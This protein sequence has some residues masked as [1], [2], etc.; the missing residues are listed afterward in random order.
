MR[1]LLVWV[2][3]A[4]V[5]AGA[6]EVQEPEGL[7]GRIQARMKE[8]LERL[9]DYVC[10]QTVER[11]TRAKPGKPLEKADTLRLEVGLIGD[12]E[13]FSWKDAGRF[14]EKDLS[15]MVGKGTVG[16]GNFALHAKHVFLARAA[17]FTY[18]GLV[19][20][21]SRKA[22]QYE[23]LVPTQ[24]SA[25]RVRV[26]PNEARV[27]FQGSFWVDAASLDLLKLGVVADEIPDAL[28]L[29]RVSDVM[30]YARVPI[31]PQDFLLPKA[32]ELAMVALDGN[33]SVNRTRLTGCRQF[34][35]DSKV[36]FDDKSTA[37]ELSFSGG[38][39][40]DRLVLPP[41]T[42]L[43]VALESEIDPE[44]AALGDAVAASLA[45]PARAGERVVA[46]QGA[47]LTG[48]LVRI[49]KKALPFPHYEVALEFDTLEAAGQRLAMTATM[50]DAGP[51]SGLI[52]QAK[53]LNPTF[54]RKRSARMDILV[55]EQQAGQ[56]ILTWE[57]KKQRIP[58]GLRMKW[59]VEPENSARLRP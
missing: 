49:E 18:K 23:Y 59:V 8:T 1:W 58:R 40:D 44:T 27:G 22:H 28:G 29:D 48:R 35:G 45:K 12:R 17:E 30:E 43:E 24:L 37:P 32:S 50:I 46:P 53:S 21:D 9:P 13:L 16:T 39:E 19:D 11:Y 52:K 57:A 14:Q 31:G 54:D 5:T 41:R 38:P 25:Y 33:E 51:H 42:M 47:M 10:V 20:L 6:Q 3:A 26:G 36:R 7:L 2:M 15:E 56:G 34:Q 4:A 55:R